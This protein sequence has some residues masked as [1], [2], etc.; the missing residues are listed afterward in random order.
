MFSIS[1][2]YPRKILYHKNWSYFQCK[3]YTFSGFYSNGFRLQWW[4]HMFFL[5][6]ALDRFGIDKII[7]LHKGKPVIKEHQCKINNKISESWAA[8]R[9]FHSQHQGTL[10]SDCAKCRLRFERFYLDWAGIKN[11]AWLKFS[12]VLEKWASS[13]AEKIDWYIFISYSRQNQENLHFWRV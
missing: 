9:R 7:S 3:Y 5:Q 2:F 13:L 6:I 12:V 11:P 4:H 1:N 10:H 8:Q